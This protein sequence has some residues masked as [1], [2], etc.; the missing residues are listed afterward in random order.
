MDLLN[1]LEQLT[2]ASGVSGSENSIAAVA[3]ELLIPYCDTVEQ[4]QGNVIGILGERQSGKPHVLL[5][6]HMDQVG[7]LVTAITE[8]GFVR[9][10]NAGGLD[11]RF[12]PAQ[13]V[14]IHG[15]QDVAGVICCMP[16]HLQNGEEHVLSVTELAIDT[17]YTKEELEQLVEAGDTVSFDMPLVPLQ[18]DFVC[19]RSLDD[20]CGM[21]SILYA[22]FLIQGEELPCSCSI[23]FST[24]EETSE[25]GATIG[26]YDIEPDIALAVDV[27]FALEHNGDATKCGSMGKGPMIGISPSLSRKVTDDLIAAADAEKIAWQ[28]EVMSGRTGTNADC[29]SVTKG[30]VCAGTISIPLRYMHTPAEVIQISDVKKTGELLAAYLRRCGTC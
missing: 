7:F 18:S 27:T 4:R 2:A 19:S 29:F 30:G 13:R 12:M 10:G 24:Q 9:V 1:L 11:C 15:K 26:A 28:P 6:A 23:L 14:V 25:R 17:G 8:G 16:P 3:Q 20:R 21:A 22:L 5:D